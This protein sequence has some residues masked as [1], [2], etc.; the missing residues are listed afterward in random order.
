MVGID[1]S[2]DEFVECEDALDV[3]D[4]ISLDEGPWVKLSNFM[5]M[6]SLFRTRSWET[7]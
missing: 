1:Q 4:S 5:G 6:M 7:N 2:K 3:I